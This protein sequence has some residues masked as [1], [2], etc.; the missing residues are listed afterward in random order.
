MYI[1]LDMVVVWLVY[2]P[3]R[4]IL[5]YVCMIESTTIRVHLTLWSEPSAEGKRS[6]CRRWLALNGAHVVIYRGSS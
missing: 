1:L 2:S 4:C 5:S 6:C 3:T